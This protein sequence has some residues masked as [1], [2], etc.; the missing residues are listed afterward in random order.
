MK[1]LL[2]YGLIVCGLFFP[3]VIILGSK[4]IKSEVN[5]WDEHSCSKE[6]FD[7]NEKVHLAIEKGTI[8]GYFD[9]NNNQYSYRRANFLVDITLNEYCNIKIFKSEEDAINSGYKEYSI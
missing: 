7:I 2:L 3:V 5:F 1:L 4:N 6:N 9:K 8:Y